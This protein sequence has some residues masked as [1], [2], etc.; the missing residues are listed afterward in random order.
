MQQL[1]A[2][3]A[4]EDPMIGSLQSHSRTSYGRDMQRMLADL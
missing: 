4:A 3:K 2:M 1:T